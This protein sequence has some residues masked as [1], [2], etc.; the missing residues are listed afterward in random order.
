[1]TVVIVRSVSCFPRILCGPTRSHTVWTSTRRSHGL[2]PGPSSSRSTCH[3]ISH[4]PEFLNYLPKVKTVPII[5][6][7]ITC[8]RAQQSFASPTR[9]S[10][11]YSIPFGKISSMSIAMRRFGTAIKAGSNSHM[12][13]ENGGRSYSHRLHGY[14]YGFLITVFRSGRSI[15]NLR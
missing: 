11:R 15:A 6:M 2:H 9:F 5:M 7:I 12:Y 8:L 13:A 3:D 14:A 4:V 10:L 1:V